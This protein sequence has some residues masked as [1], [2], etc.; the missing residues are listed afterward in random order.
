MRQ[1]LLKL[2]R[3]RSLIIFYSYYVSPGLF[4]RGFHFRADSAW[5]KW[6]YA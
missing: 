3:L 6:L 5:K 1:R 4:A 2:L